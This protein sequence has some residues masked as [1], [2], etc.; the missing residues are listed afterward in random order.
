MW[1]RKKGMLAL[2]ASGLIAASTAAAAESGSNGYQAEDCAPTSLK[3]TP[4]ECAYYDQCLR[5][6]GFGGFPMGPPA[7]S[8]TILQCDAE[9][10]MKRR[11]ESARGWWKD[12]P[13]K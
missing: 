10:R 5:G 9:V 3:L 8:P 2:V 13:V 6:Q 11:Y 7:S 12:L 1:A 4:E